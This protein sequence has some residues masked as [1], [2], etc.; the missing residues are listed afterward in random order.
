MGIVI[1]KTIKT[2][3]VTYIGV[4]LGLIS[5]LWLQTAIIS[6]LQIGILNYIVD[7]TILILPFILFGISGIPARFMH[8]FKDINEKNSFISWILLIPLITLSIST[9]LLLLFKNQ[10]INLLG[11]D[12]INYKNYLVFILPLVFCFTYQ[13]LLEAILVT[14]SHIVFPSILKNIFR[15]LILILLL[16]LYYYKNIDFFQLVSYYV[17]AHL[18]EIIGLF[19]YLRF[20]L[21]FNF[22]N[23]LKIF[24]HPKKNEIYSF[25]LYLVVGVT[26]VVMVGKLDTIM[27]SSITNDLKL[28]GIYAIAFFIGSVIEIPKRIVHQLVLP[29]MSR[30]VSEENNLELSKLYK[31]TG[32]NMAIIGVLLFLLIWFNIDELFLI[33][34]NGEKY[35][36]G[37]WVVFF[38]GLSKVLDIVFGTTD[39]IINASRHYKL[40]GILAPIL[41]ISTV[42]TNYFFITIYGI[43]G[44]AIATSLTIFIYSIIKYYMV[45]RL[46]K[47]NLI[48]TS[49][50]SILLHS[51]LVILF[52]EFSNITF[53]NNYLAI[54]FNTIMICVIFIGGNYITKTS[55]EMNSFMSNLTRKLLYK[56]KN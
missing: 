54:I 49:Y 53:S 9:I 50:L 22:S 39:L 24:S 17:L 31:Q 19:I 46:I 45:L 30:L 25:A 43:T 13:Y 56:T 29:I 23:P 14:N 7:T 27:I 44:A 35:A 51:L 1:K 52:F 47:L 48:T 16:I 40:N 37:K 26:G 41:I 32:I 11:Q 2:T 21:K 55:I 20:S 5:V 3:I 8:H 33:I 12:V 42:I 15:R 36:A 34:P 28:L 10:L 6:E 38:I 4:L 18:I